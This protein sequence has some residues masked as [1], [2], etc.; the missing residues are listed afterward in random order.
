MNINEP[1]VLAEVTPLFQRYQDAIISNDVKVLNEL[2]WNNPLTIRYGTAENLY[3]HDAIAAFR[4]TRTA[5]QHA[6]EVTKTV[7]T[8]F[9]RDCATTNIEFTR[10]GRI[11]RQS[12]A[13]VRMPEGWRIVSAHVSYMDE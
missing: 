9:G 4:T 2:F 6:R 11:G 8:T 12:Q 13:W 5:A 1:A 3:G 7:V 10:S